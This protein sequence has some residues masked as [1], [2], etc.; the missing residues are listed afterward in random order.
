MWGYSYIT[1]F[2]RSEDANATVEFV[3]VFPVI[4]LI[5]VAAFETAM[6]LTRQVILERSLDSA[7][8][9]LRLTSGVS[10]TYD[11]IRDNIC[12]NSPI[13]I[14]CQESLSLDLSVINQE[15][16]ALPDYHTLCVDRAGTVNPANQFNPGADN[17]LM[18]I[19][20]CALVDRI[21]PISGLGLDLT[22]DDTGAIHITAATIFVN[23]PE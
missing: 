16:Y 15:T 1:R 18:L 10:V 5:F 14:N 21:L 22:R 2:L 19:R 6:M 3:I 12:E 4:I 9:H 20:V 7:V 13:L 8:R 11:A 23:E 17:E